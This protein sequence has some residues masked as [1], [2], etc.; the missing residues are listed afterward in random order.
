MKSSFKSLTEIPQLMELHEDQMLE[1]KVDKKPFLL[2][3][4]SIPYRDN[5]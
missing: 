2:K 1:E 4:N 5:V 3:W